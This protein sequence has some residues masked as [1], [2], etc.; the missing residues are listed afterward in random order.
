[1]IQTMVSQAHSPTLNDPLY[2]ASYCLSTSCISLICRFSF[3]SPHCRSTA[4]MREFDEFLTIN[5]S[6][7]SGKG[8]EFP[9]EFVQGQASSK[10]FK[11]CEF[12]RCLDV[13]ST[14][15]AA[16]GF[17]VQCE[18]RA[19]ILV[20]DSDNTG[21]IIGHYIVMKDPLTGSPC[22]RIES[23][24]QEHINEAIS[25]SVAE[26]MSSLD[27]LTAPPL[28]GE[29]IE[30]LR[31]ISFFVDRV[32]TG[33]TIA[34]LNS[35]NEC[36]ADMA[37]TAPSTSAPSLNSSSS[38]PCQETNR[39]PPSHST[40]CG[41]QTF[42]AW[43]A[44]SLAHPEPLNTNRTVQLSGCQYLA[45]SD[46]ITQ[47][48]GGPHTT[49]QQKGLHPSG[50][51]FAG[52]ES[53]P[54]HNQHHHTM[55]HD[56]PTRPAKLAH[57]SSVVSTMASPCLEGQVQSP[58]HSTEPASLTISQS[59]TTFHFSTTVA[60]APTQTSP[61]QNASDGCPPPPVVPPLRLP[62][63]VQS[64][65]GVEWFGE[66]GEADDWLATPKPPLNAPIVN[67]GRLE[68]LADGLNMTG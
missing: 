8:V 25:Q 15:F 42:S 54:K 16:D 43:S 18:V 50:Q 48:G 4:Q 46:V 2:T 24:P 44:V 60:P 31:P 55:P 62:E 38:P 26:F 37:T 29:E 20:D 61:D 56:I 53:Q 17:G 33:V 5:A 27:T 67:F 68:V 41:E 64:E 3:T 19:D 13:L 52:W 12:R 36:D 35:I 22:L 21:S 58:E 10:I 9:F 51:T 57:H 7:N 59:M 11:N 49:H 65:A 28:S 63:L 66:F 32:P 23:A 14:R 40:A 47:F 30:Q 6:K 34:Q 45:Q 39:V 1:M